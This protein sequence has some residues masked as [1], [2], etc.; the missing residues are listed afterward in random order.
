M[1][2]GT[3]LASP[4]PKVFDRGR[5]IYSEGDPAY[6]AFVVVS[7][8]TKLVS[9]A[10]DGR[11]G[12]IAL[13]GPGDL[14][15]EDAFVSTTRMT[16]AD[17]IAH[18][19]R[20]QA[21]NRTDPRMIQL[22]AARVRWATTALEGLLLHDS[23]ARIARHIADLARRHGVALPHGILVRIPLSQEHI[24]QLAGTSRET[25]SKVLGDFTRAGWIRRAGSLRYL[26]TNIDALLLHGD[27]RK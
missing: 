5:P 24:A 25:A 18:G 15:G 13:A 12:M 27:L 7:G 14:F 3:A 11:Q 19:T 8:A 23:G 9:S 22:L 21:V 4:D 26:V 20:I 2:S 16:R 10:L 6:T 17:A 1:A